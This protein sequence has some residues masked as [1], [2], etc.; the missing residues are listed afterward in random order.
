MMTA[1]D[2]AAA[3][4]ATRTGTATSETAADVAVTLTSGEIAAI[5]D[6]ANLRARITAKAVRWPRSAFTGCP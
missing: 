1:T 5:T 4:A 2:A 3:R 6:R